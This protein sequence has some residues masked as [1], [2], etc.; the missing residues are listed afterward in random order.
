[1]DKGLVSP[2]GMP[3]MFAHRCLRHQETLRI[4]YPNDVRLADK[5]KAVSHRYFFISIHFFLKVDFTG[6]GK[7]QRGS[8][9]QEQTP[10]VDWVRSCARKGWVGK[11]G[12]SLAFKELCVKI[13]G[14][15]VS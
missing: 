13:K 7:M 12:V 10:S 8:K 1:M 14:N 15:V 2:R 6:K 4:S 11:S 3:V 9:W 5:D